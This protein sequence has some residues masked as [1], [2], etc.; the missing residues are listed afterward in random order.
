MPQLKNRRQREHR[1][2]VSVPM[3]ENEILTVDRAAALKS[4]SR[5]N[6]IRRTAVQRAAA[7]IR[8]AERKVSAA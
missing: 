7:A 2:P 3:A 4:E 1:F 6:F 8:A 5:A